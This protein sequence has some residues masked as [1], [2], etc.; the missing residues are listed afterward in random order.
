MA[1]YRLLLALVASCGMTPSVA[2]IVQTDLIAKRDSTRKRALG[3]APYSPTVTAD[4]PRARRIK[5]K[6]NVAQ[7]CVKQDDGTISQPH[8]VVPEEH[9]GWVHET[10]LGAAQAGL[11]VK[12]S[13]KMCSV[14]SAT[15][16]PPESKRKVL[17]TSTTNTGNF[18]H[19]IGAAFQDML[20][21]VRQN[22]RETGLFP[23]KGDQNCLIYVGA[24]ET[25]S[26]YHAAFDWASTTADAFG[27]ASMREI[28]LGQ[29]EK[30]DYDR[31]ENPGHLRAALHDCPA[32]EFGGGN[33]AKF[34]RNISHW[35]RTYPALW[36]E[37][38]QLVD[39]GLLLVFAYSAGAC[40]AGRHAFAAVRAPDSESAD[41]LKDQDPDEVA[42]WA[43][44]GT[45]DLL[46][47]MVVKPHFEDCENRKENQRKLLNWLYI[48]RTARRDQGTERMKL[49]SSDPL[50]VIGL[51]DGDHGWGESGMDYVRIDGN[52]TRICT[53]NSYKYARKKQRKSTGEE[54][55]VMDWP[56]SKGFYNVQ[57]ANKDAAV[58]WKRQWQP[59]HGEDHKM[60]PSRRKPILPADSSPQASGNQPSA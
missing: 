27:F 7:S 49:N 51:S 48:E 6:S 4:A 29:S 14:A 28:R 50:K 21:E 20:R 38:R 46:G 15:D 53:S 18:A 19:D 54:V 56:R 5:E 39:R 41:F 23:K 2:V 45:L 59:G 55:M 13:P 60:L 34:A 31:M 17:I 35:K 24:D 10:H 58:L 40:I 57:D 36:T 11:F 33:P 3:A 12:R 42:T 44:H 52:K 22:R 16:I 1:R 26:Y 47:N 8:M 30:P 43:R 25:D 37:F 9:S 32:I